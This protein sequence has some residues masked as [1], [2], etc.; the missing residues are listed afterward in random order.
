MRKLLYSFFKHE[1]ASGLLLILAMILALLAANSPLHELYNRLLALPVTVAAGSFSIAKP[2][3]LWINDG[4]MAIFFL[5]IGLELK[6]E[7]LVGQLNQLSKIMLPAIAALG[8][9]LVPALVYAFINRGDSLALQG[10]AVPTA[11]DIAFALG[12]LSLLGTRV[13]A[14]L[15]IFL[16]S[17]AIFDDIGAIVIIA[18]FYTANV[19]L[20]ALTVSLGGLL[21]LWCMNKRG[22]LSISAYLLVGLVVWASLLKS[23]VHA[24]L[25]GIAIAMFIPLSGKDA[26]GEEHQPLHKLEE[27]LHTPVAFIILPLFAFANAGLPLLGL[28]L[29]DLLSPVPLG[30][31]LGLFLGKQIGVMGFTWLAVKLRLGKLSDDI[32]WRQ[33]YGLSLLCGVGFTMSLFISSLAFE[34]VAGDQLLHD[35]LGILLGSLLSAVTG[36][37]WLRYFTRQPG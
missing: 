22:I 5:L 35:R 21:V 24:T 33:V 7:I 29:S 11:T 3:L 2:L 27:D 4:L 28:Q 30:I 9:M 32:S 17:L 23:G 34:Q 13:P 14:S 19:S 1:S 26:Q 8:G 12:I 31:A 37:I 15:K 6:R 18:I 20:L 25:A 36:Y 10:W 16:V